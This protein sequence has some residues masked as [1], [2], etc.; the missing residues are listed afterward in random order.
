MLKIQQKPKR[1]FY[2]NYPAFTAPPHTSALRELAS[3]R[4]NVAYRRRSQAVRQRFA[5][6]SLV[7]SNPT[8]ALVHLSAHHKSAFLL[9]SRDDESTIA[10]QPFDNN[11]RE[12][13]HDRCSPIGIAFTELYAVYSLSLLRGRY[14]SPCVQ[15]TMLTMRVYVGL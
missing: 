14:V 9:Y 4:Y 5:K 7:G 6:P 15:G 2:G 11:T 1:R 10:T 12:R 3:I 13:Y 8:V